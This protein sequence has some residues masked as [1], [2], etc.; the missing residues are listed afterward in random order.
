MSRGWGLLYNH[1]RVLH[2]DHVVRTGEVKAA[3]VDPNEDHS[4]HAGL[5]VLLATIGKHT[6][7]DT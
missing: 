4:G 2:D 7:S 5:A 1:Q 3:K 6:S